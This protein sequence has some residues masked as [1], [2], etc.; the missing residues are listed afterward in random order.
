MVRSVLEDEEDTEP[1]PYIGSAKMSDGI[2]TV[3]ASIQETIGVNIADFRA[4]TSPEDAFA[5]LRGGAEAAGVFVLLISNL[6]SYHSAIDLDTFRGF[7]LADNIA[8]FVVINEQDAK[9]A[10]SFTLLHELA[11]LWLGQTGVSGA[12]AGTAMERF[13]NDLAGEFLLPAKELS[14][15][16]VNDDTNFEIASQR[17]SEFARDRHL[18]RTMVAYKLLRTDAISQ[19][20]WTRISAS[21]RE[22]WLRDRAIRRERDKD[23]EGGP[24]YYVVRRH[25]LG[26]ALVDLVGRTMSEGVLTPTKAGKVLGVKPRNVEP[27]LSGAVPDSRRIA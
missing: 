18:S 4:Q 21:F 25:R 11:H 7:A 16:E 27:L 10:W 23:V 6:G 9:S 17:I 22:Q 13:C 5:L 24:N 15:L 1:L 3:L 19:D 26:A 12:S 14:E 2:P 8:P 20:T